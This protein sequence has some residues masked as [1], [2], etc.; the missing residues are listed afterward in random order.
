[1]SL[2]SSRIRVGRK[3]RC[4]AP[5]VSKRYATPSRETAGYLLLPLLLSVFGIALDTTL[6]NRP[7]RVR[8]LEST[9]TAKHT[10]DE[11]RRIKA[12]AQHAGLT[13]SEWARE[14]HLDALEVPPWSHVLLREIMAL[15]KIVL[16]LELDH[17]QGQL[18]TESR[19]R[20]I[21]ENAESTKHAMADSRL[22][23]N[24][25]GDIRE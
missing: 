12:A 7:R 22:N 4:C 13:V 11:E 21:I 23:A 15:R 2:R 18:P 9:V 3:R 14:T 17:L 25:K 8:S 1:M 24:S 10:A 6:M 19:L 5:G 20:S 16:A